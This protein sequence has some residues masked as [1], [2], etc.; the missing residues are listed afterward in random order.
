MV[1]GNTW[2]LHHDPDRFPEP[3]VFRPERY[4]AYPLTAPEYAAMSG[5]NDRDHWG[6]GCVARSTF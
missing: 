1:I 2:G 6:Y 4:A 3:Q 5:D